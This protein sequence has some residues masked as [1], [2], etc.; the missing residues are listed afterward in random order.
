[1]EKMRQPDL[2]RKASRQGETVLDDHYKNS[3][4][5]GKGVNCKNSAVN[6]IQTYLRRLPDKGKRYWTAVQHRHKR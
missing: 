3:V 5:Y 4:L 2:P 1:M 6:G